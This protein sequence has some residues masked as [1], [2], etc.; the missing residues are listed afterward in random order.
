M[1]TLSIR[2]K[3]KPSDMGYRYIVT[4]GGLSHTA[5]RTKRAFK[6]WLQYTGLQI[7]ERFG[8]G[9]TIRL[10]G[11]YSTILEWLDH[12]DFVDKF[13]HLKSFIALENGDYVLGFIEPT[14]NG[15]LLHIQNTNCVRLPFNYAAVRQYEDY[16]TKHWPYLTN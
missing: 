13:G 10:V 7:G 15:N 3:D 9:N 8:N 6:I 14:V 12:D 11:N 1:Y 5:F 2:D 16:G 4:Q